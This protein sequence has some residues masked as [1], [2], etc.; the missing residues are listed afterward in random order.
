M[1]MR[2]FLV[3]RPIFKEI[4]KPVVTLDDAGF[5]RACRE[6]V[7]RAR[8]DGF[9]PDCIVGIESG[10]A[11]VAEHACRACHDG[12]LFLTCRLQRPTTA[13]KR[14]SKLV[15]ALRYMPYVLSNNLRRIED[16]V[17]ARRNA[18][19]GNRP[20]PRID[21]DAMMAE[22]SAR[23]ARRVLILDDAVDSGVTML[24]LLA[25]LEPL[26]STGVTIRT[27]A[28]NVSRS[29]ARFWPDYNIHSE[30]LCRFPWSHD[31]RPAR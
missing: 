14:K 29:D 12:V 30:V 7:E 18:K 27:A 25:A 16:V 15:H 31:A 28:I 2:M 24:A 5:D 23:G 4:L 10:G 21:V 8:R 13:G 22:I 20:L 1:L 6:L 19:K 9:E 3:M 26:R 17:L 11:I